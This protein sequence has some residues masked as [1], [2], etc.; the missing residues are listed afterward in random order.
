MNGVDDGFPA[1]EKLGN[2]AASIIKR[3]DVIEQN[4]LINGYNSV[5][6]IDHDDGSQFFNDTHN[7]MVFGGCKNY[8]GNSKSCDA[9][10]IVYPGISSRSAGSYRCACFAGTGFADQYFQ[11]NTCLTADGVVYT[12]GFQQPITN[13]TDASI[14]QHV[15]RTAGNTFFAPTNL[16]TGGLFGGRGDQCASFELWQAAE[17]DVGS[18]AVRSL[19]GPDEVVAMG[20]RVLAFPAAGQK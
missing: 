14:G 3:L 13:C 6:T 7:F 18:H 12:Y 8:L 15:Y 9:N 11:N 5:W 1:S 2:P 4:F 16:S 20:R 10:V 17:Q 19:P